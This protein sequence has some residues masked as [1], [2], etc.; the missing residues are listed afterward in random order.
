MG[1]YDRRN[2]PAFAAGMAITSRNDEFAPT[3]ITNISHG[4]SLGGGKR[5]FGRRGNHDWRS[6]KLLLG[7]GYD[8]CHIFAATSWGKRC[9]AQSKSNTKTA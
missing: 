1:D 6:P 2:C 3:T 9:L 7:L 5:D 8:F 4:R